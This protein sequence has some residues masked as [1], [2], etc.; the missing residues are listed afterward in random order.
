MLT[1][2]VSIQN[3]IMEDI[4]SGELQPGTR[5]E[6][7]DLAERY[8]VSRTPVREAL[9]HLA[10][11]GI[12]EFRP[13]HGVYIADLSVDCW[14]EILE[15]TA[16]LEASAARYAALRM[17]PDQ[18]DAL[19]AAHLGMRHAVEHCDDIEFDRQ[20]VSLHEMVWLGARNQTLSESIARMRSRSMPYTRL[21]YMVQKTTAMLSYAEHE[22]VVRAIIGQNPELAYQAMRAHVMRAG[23]LEE[24]LRPVESVA[25]E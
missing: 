6:E 25:A 21:E 13:R 9:R 14:H 1:L 20:N 8:D 11:T 4:C 19:L 3:Q 15:V 17:T 2:A 10:A 18:R 7:K 22:S 16:D 12:V 24:E 23:M 5:L